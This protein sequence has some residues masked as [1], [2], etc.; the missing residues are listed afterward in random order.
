MSDEPIRAEARPVDT[1]T[2]G[3]PTGE[4]PVVGSTSAVPDEIVIN[5][6]P[7]LPRR[8][9]G[10]AALAVALLV[11][12]GTAVAVG[13]ATGAAYEAATIVAW[14]AIG[15]SGVVVVAGLLA[16]AADRGRRWGVAAVLI[17]VAANP[18]L[19]RSILALFGEPA[20]A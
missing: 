19:L 1:V 11:V 17:G 16:I 5:A 13:L 7:R 8:T 4:I 10:V 18:F 15:A 9:L 2:I 6:E 3:V 20:T 12:V 14:L